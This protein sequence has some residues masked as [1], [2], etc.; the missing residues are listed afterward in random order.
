MLL[1]PNP[2]YLLNQDGRALASQEAR[3]LRDPVKYFGAL[4]DW[5]K[6]AERFAD[7][8]LGDGSWRAMP[9]KRRAAFVASVRHNFY[10]WDAV[11]DEQSTIEEWRALSARTLVVSD[12]AT[13]L[14]IREIVE[15]FARACPHWAFQ[16][17][18]EGGHMAPLM[19][20]E[21][22]NP[23]VRK[24]LHTALNGARGDS[25][26]SGRQHWPDQQPA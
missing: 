16:F 5:P 25:P 1:E 26:T 2:I 21:L 18:A 19:R 15:R 20:P 3:D 8:W 13:R 14:P 12:P 17:I 7:Y 6:V 24:C 22:I 11:M 9:D 10:E 23:L 4:G